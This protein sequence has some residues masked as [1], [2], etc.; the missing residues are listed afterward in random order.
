MAADQNIGKFSF[1]VVLRAVTA[2]F[3]YFFSTANVQ[4]RL[5]QKGGFYDNG[6]S[7][8]IC[9]RERV[10]D[11]HH[12]GN[13]ER[14]ISREVRVSR[15]YVNNVIKRYTEANTS[16]RAPKVCFGP[17]KVDRYAS[18]YIEAQRLMK[19]SIYASEI[20][21]RLLLDGV[22][23]PNDLPSNSQINKLSRNEHAMTR[24]KIS[25]IPRESTTTDVTEKTD[26][27]LYEISTF[28]PTQLHFFDESG[29]IK[30]TGNRSY[31]SAPVGVPAFE[32]QRYSSNANY[33][34]NLMHSIAGVDF[35]NIL[36]GPSNGMELLNFF[37]EALQLEREDGS[38]V[39]EHGDC[40]IMDNCG[41]HHAR[42][43]EPVLRAML[44]DCGVGLIYQ[45]P[46]SPDFN[47][48][49][50]CFHQI[51]SFLQRYQSLAEHETKIAIADGILEIT[52][53]QSWSFFHHVGYV[54]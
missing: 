21:Q 1:E 17:K 53:Q 47:T 54:F 48:C 33:T 14:V 41:F 28:H 20:R 35:F 39:L 49:E 16:L 9:H 4:L 46:Y 24:K 7:L 12:D 32:V 15:T 52:P 8:S 44:G 18:E 27:Y 10:L 11:L 3:S 25:V 6:R 2:H 29:V 38:A 23:H 5:N 36:D 40:V 31:G 37:D 22:L 43:V 30:T 45:P 42:F 50:M 51:K 26:D 19:P 34:I 13:S